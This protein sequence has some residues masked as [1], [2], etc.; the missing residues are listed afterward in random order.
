MNKENKQYT[1]SWF[2]E[3]GGSTW[4]TVLDGLNAKQAL[5]IGCY[6][7]QASV[8]LLDKFPKMELQVVDIFDPTLA[9]DWDGYT[10]VDNGQTTTY[11]ERFDFNVAEYG[12]RVFKYRGKSFNALAGFV[13][14]EDLRFDFI[15]IDGDHRGLP[16][17]QD[18]VMAIELL[19]KGGIM[20]IDD[21]RDI[22]WLHDAVDAFLKLLPTDKY[23]FETTPDGSQM[24]VKRIK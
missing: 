22:V 8:Y 1:N 9:E 2:A 14:D 15:F 5:E 6:E 17:T 19:N 10:I 4:D 23:S 24:V 16:A 21:Y 18:C 11:E 20:I 3:R 12:N 7:G 13:G